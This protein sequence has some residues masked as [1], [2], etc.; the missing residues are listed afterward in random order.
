M[1]PSTRRERRKQEVHGRIVDAAMGLFDEFGFHATTVAEICDRADVAQKTLFNHFESK[2]HVLRA[3]AGIAL[4]EFLTQIE[5]IRKEP[6]TVRKRLH[7]LFGEIADTVEEA[8]PMRRELVAEIVHIAHEAGTE[9]EQALRLHEA[10]GAILRDAR[11][12]GELNSTHSLQ[13]QTEMVL[14]AFY[15]LMFNWANLDAYP[16]RR[17]ALA[18]ARALADALATPTNQER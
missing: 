4:D 13:T 10:F 14:G 8:G 2:A 5:A 17:Q 9:K 6:G 3:I 7:R 18:I 11:A 16:V 1:E 12:L 15:A